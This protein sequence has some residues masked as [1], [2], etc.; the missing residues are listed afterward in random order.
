MAYG[1]Y[2]AAKEKGRHEEIAFVG[3]DGL[4]NEGTKYVQDGILAATFEYPLCVDKA[5]ELAV[6]LLNESDFQPEKTYILQSRAF[7]R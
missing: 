1:A 3:V 6:R 7:T 4:S 2:L 5:V